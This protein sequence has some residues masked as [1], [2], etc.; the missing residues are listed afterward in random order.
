L[1][2]FDC[3]N[4]RLAQLGLRQDGFADAVAAERGPLGAAA[5]LVY[6]RD[7]HF[8]DS[9]DGVGYRGATRRPGP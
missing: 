3:R 2:Q 7:Q 8:R 4:N 9:A 1:K 6:F 5:E